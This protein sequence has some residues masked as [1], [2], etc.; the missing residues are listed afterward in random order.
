MR[1]PSERWSMLESCLASVTGLRRG[2]T[3]TPVPIFKRLV[4]AA[5]P[6]STVSELMIGKV[7]LNAKQYVVPYPD[8]VVAELLDADA[9]L[10]ELFRVGHF[11][12]GGEI[13][14]GDAKR[15]GETLHQHSSG[16]RVLQAVNRRSGSSALSVSSS[17]PVGGSVIDRR[18]V[19]EKLE[20][21]VVLNLCA[22]RR[23]D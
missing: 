19:E 3:R 2:R 5:M 14:R 21:R 1:R 4:R 16:T 18:F 7:R 17:R 11:R 15:L 23:R 12:I 6:V 8:R 9:I 22:A 13:A 10:D 20:T